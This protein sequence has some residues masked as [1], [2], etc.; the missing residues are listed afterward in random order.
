ME[1]AGPRDRKITELFLLT[2]VYGGDVWGAV[3]TEDKG[4]GAVSEERN[5]KS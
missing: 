1:E 3:R 4:D 2:E 5:G